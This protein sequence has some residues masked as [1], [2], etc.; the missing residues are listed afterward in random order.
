VDGLE[1]TLEQL[2]DH[3]PRLWPVRV[4][5]VARRLS[6]VAD[7]ADQDERRRA[8]AHL[9]VD[10][11]AVLVGAGGLASDV[12][13]LT[14]DGGHVHEW[15]NRY[16]SCTCGQRHPADVAAGGAGRR[17]YPALVH[18]TADEPDPYLGPAA[19]RPGADIQP[20]RRPR[21]DGIDYCSVHDL[22]G[23]CPYDHSAG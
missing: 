1:H 15:P 6:D 8:A 23:P 10:A 21:T 19:P 3:D 20:A 4:R 5:A 12:R 17:I 22:D 13:V 9:V 11:L 7:A 2:R 16:R 14:G 18:D